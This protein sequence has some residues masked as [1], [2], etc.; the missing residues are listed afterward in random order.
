[1]RGQAPWKAA[2]REVPPVELLIQICSAVTDAGRSGWEEK[3]TPGPVV[4]L[5]AELNALWGLPEAT[6][7]GL[8]RPE[9]KPGAGVPPEFASSSVGAA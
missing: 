9:A 5:P 6:V 8:P 7:N 1:M 2:R 3:P 4:F